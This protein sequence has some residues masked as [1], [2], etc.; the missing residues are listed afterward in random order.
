ML[1]SVDLLLPLV[2]VA[3]QAPLSPP[4]PAPSNI[5]SGRQRQTR[6]LCT[7]IA[8][9][10]C[11]PPAWLRAERANFSSYS[12]GSLRWR[13]KTLKSSNSVLLGGDTCARKRRGENW[14]SVGGAH[15]RP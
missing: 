14:A 7:V 8:S 6:R 4:V 10:L 12:R 1:D 9:T 2:L 13:A 5:A 11:S 15:G 3:C